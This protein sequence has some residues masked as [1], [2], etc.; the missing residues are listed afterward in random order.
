MERSALAD[1]R[2]ANSHSAG[3]AYLALPPV[4][5]ISVDD[6]A[7]SGKLNASV[8]VSSGS[9]AGRH[10]IAVPLAVLT[11]AHFCAIE[12]VRTCRA[13]IGVVRTHAAVDIVSPHPSAFCWS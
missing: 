7:S 9:Y 3:R 8:E 6:V 2:S 5:N 10:G 11:S 12:H 1:A 4:R 13:G